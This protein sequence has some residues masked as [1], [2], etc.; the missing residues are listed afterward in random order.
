[1]YTFSATG[2]LLRSIS[3]LPPTRY[4]VDLKNSVSCAWRVSSRGRGCA[5]GCWHLAAKST[6]S[7]FALL[8][9]GLTTS[10]DS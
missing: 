7:E 1:L 4:P 10:K 9:T 5:R 6:A 3:W 8:S 2:I